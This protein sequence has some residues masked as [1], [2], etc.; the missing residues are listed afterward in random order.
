MKLPLLAGFLFPMVFSTAQAF[1][2][3]EGYFIAKG[4]CE[5]YQSKNSLA[6]PGARF[7][8]PMQAYA[9]RGINKSA[10]DFYQIIYPGAPVTEKRWVHVSC[11][12]HVVDAKTMPS[13][14]GNSAD[15]DNVVDSSEESADNLLALSWQP[16]FCEY[17]PNKA[18]CVDL[19]DG[20]LPVTEQQL[21]IHGLWAQPRGKTY[22]GVSNSLKRIDSKNQW[23]L[24]PAPELSTRTREALNASMPGT[25]SLLERHEWIKHGT[26]HLGQGGADEYFADTLKVTHA[27]NESVVARFFAEHVGSQVNTNDIREK[28]DAV[29]GIGAGKRVQF[30]CVGDQKRVL[31]Q[32]ITINLKGVITDDVS[33][34]DLIMAGDETSLGC[35]E[36]IIDAVGLQ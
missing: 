12:I 31:L 4:S 11:G 13:D 6:N 29:F 22:C 19:N 5:T 30:H 36:G 21:S 18:E 35:P 24:L 9:I 26:C 28:F 33:V 7:T 16:A 32:E 1:M 15:D 23:Q 27:I 3:L 10:G 14:D 8:E 17:R 2:S 20:N 25:L 34:A